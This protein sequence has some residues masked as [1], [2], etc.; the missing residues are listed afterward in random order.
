MK[1]APFSVMALLFISCVHLNAV[2]VPVEYIKNYDGDTLTVN[3]LELKNLDHYSFFWKEISIR[4]AGVDTPEIKGD[5]DNENKAA[6]EAKQFVARKLQSA[7]RI[8]LLNPMRDK[9][10]RI[11][12]DVLVDGAS[13]SQ[14]LLNRD[15]AVP[16][17]G[18]TKHKMWCPAN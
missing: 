17:D 15:Y 12:A 18:G 9:Y 14:M 8:T 13:L 10:F 6:Q 5:C 2:E 1:S 7:R 4:L 16:Y 3:L 11:V